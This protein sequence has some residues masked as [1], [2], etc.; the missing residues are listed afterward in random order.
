MESLSMMLKSIFIHEKLS[1]IAMETFT[2]C[3]WSL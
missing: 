3:P 2:N 1:M